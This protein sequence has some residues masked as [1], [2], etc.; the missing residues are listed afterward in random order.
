MPLASNDGLPARKHGARFSC[1][2]LVIMEDCGVKQY[3]HINE[4]SIWVTD[5]SVQMEDT[6]CI[7]Q[8]MANVVFTRR[9]YNAA[10]A[11]VRWTT[12]SCVNTA[13]TAHW[14]HF[15]AIAVDIN[16]SNRLLFY[17]ISLHN[18]TFI[19]Y[20]MTIMTWFAT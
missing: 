4:L 6:R 8:F 3:G 13:Y 18:F 1:C 15:H 2:M 9:G 7:A 14:V 17:T 16:S 5:I 10:Y 19:K 12:R 11:P 20:L